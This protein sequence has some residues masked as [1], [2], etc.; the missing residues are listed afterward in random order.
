MFA[1]HRAALIGALTR[2]DS[3]EGL[4][5]GGRAKRASGPPAA[6]QNRRPSHKTGAARSRQKITVASTIPPAH[7]R[8]AGCHAAI[9]AESVTCA[10]LTSTPSTTKHRHF[11]LA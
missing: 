11:K 8:S 6:L 2:T 9:A 1:D 4:G 7:A 5:A 10:Q 3:C